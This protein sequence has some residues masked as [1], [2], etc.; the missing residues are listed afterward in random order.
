MELTHA[1]LQD[2]EAIECFMVEKHNKKPKAKGK[3]AT[4]QPNSRV[5]RSARHLGA[6][7]VKS[8][9]R[10]AVRIFAS[11]AKPM[12]VPTIPTTPW[13][14]VAMTAMVSPLGSSR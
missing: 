10:V 8:L 9:R 2:L 6:R 7:P 3:T 12:V 13:T 4:A 11:I 5:I 1:L 14:A